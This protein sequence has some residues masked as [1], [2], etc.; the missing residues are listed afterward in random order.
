[1]KEDLEKYLPPKEE[2]ILEVALTPIE[3]T[4]YKSIY[5]KNASV[6]F[7]G[8]KPGNT[9]SLMNDMMD[10]IHCCN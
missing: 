7:K 10:L 4:Y 9:P 5:E 6:L 2:T 1:M 3:K 8:A